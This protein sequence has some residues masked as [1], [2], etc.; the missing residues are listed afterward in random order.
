MAMPTAE[1]EINSNLFL[2]ND[3]LG[4]GFSLSKEGFN[5]MEIGMDELCKLLLVIVVIHSLRNK[6]VRKKFF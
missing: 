5:D 3:F 4:D 1:R 6:I 2:L